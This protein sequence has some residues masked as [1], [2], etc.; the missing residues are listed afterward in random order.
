MAQRPS[1]SERGI[2]MWGA[3]ISSRHPFCSSFLTKGAAAEGLKMGEIENLRKGGGFAKHWSA[4]A[5]EIEDDR[6][7]EKE[8]RSEGWAH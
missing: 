3:T 4:W 7:M 8:D 5:L 2:M 1:S 6:E